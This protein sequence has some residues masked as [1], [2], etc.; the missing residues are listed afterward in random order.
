MAS[1]TGQ[2]KRESGS[3]VPKTRRD[4]NTIEYKGENRFQ[5]VPSPTIPATT[6]SSNRAERVK[7]EI[8]RSRITK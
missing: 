7:G 6:T 3:E 2:K 8:I 5:N 4:T 1:V